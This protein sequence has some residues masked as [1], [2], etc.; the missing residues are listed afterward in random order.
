MERNV[1]KGREEEEEEE[2][3]I[4]KETKKKKGEDKRERQDGKK[5][6]KEEEKDEEVAAGVTKQ[7]VSKRSWSS[8]RAW[9]RQLCN[10]RPML[11]VPKS[12]MRSG[13]D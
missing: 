5:E 7:E 4:G 6:V 9:N 11:L 10:P 13:V 3:E 12:A 8:R 1:G 2:K